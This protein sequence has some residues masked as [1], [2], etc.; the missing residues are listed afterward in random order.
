MISHI[1]TYQIQEKRKISYGIERGETDGQQPAEELGM[2]LSHIREV[3]TG[4]WTAGGTGGGSRNWELRLR[5]S[6]TS[7]SLFSISL[8][9]TTSF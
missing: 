3:D 1:L 8:I 9:N 5:T 6:K 2:G 7:L 4:P